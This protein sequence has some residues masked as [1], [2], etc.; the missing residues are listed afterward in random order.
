M[1]IV[2]SAKEIL[3]IMDRASID[4]TVDAARYSLSLT[5][6]RSHCATTTISA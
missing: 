2:E 6:V 4:L 5:M 1:A 3:F